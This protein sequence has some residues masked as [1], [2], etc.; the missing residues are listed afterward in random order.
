MRKLVINDIEY[1]LFV[2]FKE[3]NQKFINVRRE[4]QDNQYCWEATY[5]NI[6]MSWRRY[7]K[8]IKNKIKKHQLIRI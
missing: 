6:P 8:L 4:V 3:N 5:R 1:K 7:K 2:R